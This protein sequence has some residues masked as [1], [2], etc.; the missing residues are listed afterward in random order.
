ME[1]LPSVRQ[2]SPPDLR[3]VQPAMCLRLRLR[4][5]LLAAVAGGSKCV[6]AWGGGGQN[7]AS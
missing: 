6:C 7:V 3:N 1:T 4:R 5:V 2:L